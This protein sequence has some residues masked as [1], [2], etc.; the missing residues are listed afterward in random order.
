MAKELISETLIVTAIL[1]GLPREFQTIIIIILG[2][3]DA[4]LTVN[5]IQTKLCAMEHT[6]RDARN[7]S[8][9]ATTMLAGKSNVICEYCKWPGHTEDQWYSKD[10]GKKT[11]FPPNAKPASV[12]VMSARVEPPVQVSSV[13]RG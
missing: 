9:E 4:T 6:I 10:P 5:T 1:G 2:S 3:E 12:T 13:L 11:K 7:L 8:P